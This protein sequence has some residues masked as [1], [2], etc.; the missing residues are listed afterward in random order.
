MTEVHSN[1]GSAGEEGGGGPRAPQDLAA[2]VASRIC[3]DVVS[4][5]GAIANGVEL[6]LLSGAERSPEIDLVADSVE[7]ATARIRFFRLA[8]GAAGGKGVARGEITSI[9]RAIEKNSRLVFDWTPMGEHPREQVKAV[10][11]LLQCMEAALPLGGRIRVSRE[12][13]VWTVEAEGPRLRIDQPAWD[14]LGPARASP[15]PG[16]AHVQFALLPAALDALG[17]PLEL[18]LG[19]ERILARF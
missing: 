18:S 10:F 13:E 5:L 8:Y 2:A 9:L 17:R 1:D 6:M 12:T 14:A 16:G 7:G 11:L 3:H 19:P 15:P 4:P